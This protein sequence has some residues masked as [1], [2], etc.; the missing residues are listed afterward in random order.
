MA[1]TESSVS[2][3]IEPAAEAAEASAT[4]AEAEL[5]ALEEVAAQEEAEPEVDV[6]ITV[7]LSAVLTYKVRTAKSKADVVFAS[8]WLVCGIFF[9]AVEVV[10]LLA[11]GVASQWP[12]C[13]EQEEW[14]DCPSGTVC[15]SFPEGP[16][17]PNGIDGFNQPKCRDCYF[18]ADT[19]GT[20]S[21][22]S[23]RV[24]NGSVAVGML[25]GKD[26]KTAS[27][28]CL[29]NRD[30][31]DPVLRFMSDTNQPASFDRCLY[32]Q[33][34]LGKVFVLDRMVLLAV[35]LLVAMSMAEDQRQQ[36]LMCRLR[37]ILLPLPLRPPKKTMAGILRWLGILLLTI[38]EFIISLAAP[39]LPFGAISL[40]LTQGVDASSAL[41]NGLSMA[42]VLQIDEFV[43]SLFLSSKVI[44]KI[45]T[46]L[47]AKAVREV[48]KKDAAGF[49]GHVTASPFIAV[50]T[51]L[52]GFI[53]Q[54]YVLFNESGSVNCE[55]LIFLIHS[56]ATIVSGIW[57]TGALCFATE[58]VTR[59][60][61][62]RRQR[63]LRNPPGSSRA[64]P[65]GTEVGGAGRVLK[66]LVA[67]ARHFVY[68]LIAATTLNL[69]AFVF[70]F[71]LY[72]RIEM[73]AMQHIELVI[74]NVFGG[75]DRSESAMNTS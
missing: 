12:H 69:L 1:T 3:T 67:P 51:V 61:V 66:M 49:Y 38:N 22:D 72:L 35:F 21:Y 64:I 42:F 45:E 44:A 30:D 52:V 63:L 10:A 18:Y 53:T 11:I 41:L 60:I 20:R 16:G 9:A 15:V 4:E 37:R 59:A 26:T 28:I 65:E 25:L 24:F 13:F 5:E 2:V 68:L 40:M 57:S 29:E 47:V 50:A 17:I 70:S 55:S 54:V 46:Y 71:E 23:E 58:T 31:L 75:I 48:A 27:D 36:L 33:E 32:V 14:G 62:G 19:D 56:H 74:R 34:T 7:N 39:L 8:I 43:P 6:A 73:A